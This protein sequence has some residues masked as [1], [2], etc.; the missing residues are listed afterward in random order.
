M[1]HVFIR[2]LEA[3]GRRWEGCKDFRADCKTNQFWS[4][5]KF[6]KEHIMF[7]K[8]K[9]SMVESIDGVYIICF[10]QLLL[11]SLSFLHENLS[12]RNWHDI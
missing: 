11:N 10:P 5:L 1:L 3:L 4:H 8:K 2:A 6:A 12:Y 9:I 7:L